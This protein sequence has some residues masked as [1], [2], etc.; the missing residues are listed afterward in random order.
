MAIHP[1]I[2]D[3]NG[4]PLTGR[5]SEVITKRYSGID[6]SGQAISLPVDVKEVLIHIEGTTEVARFTGTAGGSQQ[7]RFT[8]DGMT[9]NELPLVKEADETIIT[10]A[11]PSGTF[12]VSVIGWR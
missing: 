2:R 12:D 7:V 11:A 10:V 8:S 9:L 5:G 4:I 1:T 3:D 6:S